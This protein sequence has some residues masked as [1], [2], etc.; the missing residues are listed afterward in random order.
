M[1]WLD[2]HDY[3][4][5]EA[6]ARDRIDDLRRTTDI[7]LTSIHDPETRGA[8]PSSR[9]ARSAARA[10][11]HGPVLRMEQTPGTRE[12]C[13]LLSASFR[14]DSN[15]GPRGER[16]VEVTPELHPAAVAVQPAK[17]GSG[18][19]R[20]PGWIANTLPDSGKCASWSGCR[21][22]RAVVT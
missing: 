22:S 6:S 14:R 11:E 7:A 20:T 3:L 9:R 12:R 2:A 17:Y 21:V 13:A 1:G 18:S 10:I 16:L 19:P 5:M 4:S 15:P 8:Q